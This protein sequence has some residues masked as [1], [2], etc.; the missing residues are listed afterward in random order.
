MLI[1][2]RTWIIAPSVNIGFLPNL[3]LTR[4]KFEEVIALVRKHIVGKIANSTGV[5]C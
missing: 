4:P 2:A 5:L 1:L 3:L